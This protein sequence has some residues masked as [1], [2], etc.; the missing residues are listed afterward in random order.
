M[1]NILKMLNNNILEI[2]SNHLSFLEHDA[3]EIRLRINC[4]VLV[5]GINGNYYLDFNHISAN[6]DEEFYKVSK[7]DIDN[8]VAK[9]TL[10]S[11]HAFEK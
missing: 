9:L 8:T 2:I 4:P 10:N 6:Y 3:Y 1:N 5:K 7:K 11:I